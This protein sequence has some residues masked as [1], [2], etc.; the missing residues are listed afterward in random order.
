MKANDAEFPTSA[1]G[2]QT[3]D[4]AWRSVSTL[5][6][7]M[8]LYGGLGWLIGKRFGHQ[9]AYMAA[10]LILGIC[11]GLYVTYKRVTRGSR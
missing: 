3:D 11:L 2:R 6:A 8:L 9:S 7:G 5:T 1:D 10:G 4:M